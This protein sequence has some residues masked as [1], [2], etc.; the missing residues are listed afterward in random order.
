MR[1]NS[2]RVGDATRC[3]LRALTYL[4]RFLRVLIILIIV[5]ITAISI[6]T[7]KKLGNCLRLVIIVGYLCGR[8]PAYIFIFTYIFIFV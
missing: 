1:N 4:G 7:A 3:A 2:T 6:L 5:N 8:T